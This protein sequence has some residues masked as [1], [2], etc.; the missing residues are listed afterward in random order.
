MAGSAPRGWDR[1]LTDRDREVLK[2]WGKTKPYGFGQR[3]VLLIVDDVYYSVGTEREPILESIKRWP[4]SCGLDGWEAIDRTATLLAAARA[5]G[6]PVVH[7]RDLEG[8]PSPWQIWN[9]TEG[10][11]SNLDHLLDAERRRWNQIVDELV[12]ADGE[13][14]IDRPAPSIF[15]GSPLQFHLNYIGADTL[16]VCGETTS[17]CVRATVVDGATARYHMVVVEDCCF[18]R[19]EASHWM[20][21]FDMHTKYADVVDTMAATE[22]LE[23]AADWPQRAIG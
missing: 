17:G 20:N 21:L 9:K 19:T 5:N 18:D 11:R 12:P 7:G 3:P 14:V 16:L 10:R 2:T 15:Q 1:F 13:L 22:Y 6:I 4:M 23:T 8:F